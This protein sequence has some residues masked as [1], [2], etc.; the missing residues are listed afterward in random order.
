[1]QTDIKIRTANNSDQDFIFS[2]SPNL[3]QEAKLKWHTEES[4]QLM[5]DKYIEEMLAPTT[6]P[7]ATLIAERKGQA[8]GFV[9]ARTKR[10]DI[11]GEII[12]TIPLLAVT[13][14]AQGA[15]V[16]R[17]LMLEAEKWAKSIG[18]RL[19]HLEVFANNES[20]QAFYQRLEFKA[21]MI[22]MVKPIA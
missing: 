13:E 4:V 1:M 20:A 8:L 6:A 15:G 5:Q 21:E 3:A 16:G 17:L 18:C 10:D 22:H 11:S 14:S 7:T 19:L 9:H 2:L 12:G